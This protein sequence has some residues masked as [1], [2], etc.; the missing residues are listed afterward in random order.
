[1]LAQRLKAL[2]SNSS[3]GS[4]QTASRHT[5]AMRRISFSR[6]RRVFVY[7]GGGARATSLSLWPGNSRSRK[8]LR[9][10]GSNLI[11]RLRAAICQ[12]SIRGQSPLALSS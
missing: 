6:R 4:R 9:P 11:A 8:G 1:L 5:S 3:S 2:R 7:A 10:E 12:R